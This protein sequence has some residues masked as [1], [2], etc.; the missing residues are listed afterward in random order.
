MATSTSTIAAQYAMYEVMVP[1]LAT[2]LYPKIEKRNPYPADVFSQAPFRNLDYLKVP[3]VCSWIK[4]FL[5]F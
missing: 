2:D 4:H 1:I 3:N 5:A